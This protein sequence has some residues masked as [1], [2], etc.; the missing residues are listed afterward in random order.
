MSERARIQFC[1]SV[2]AI[3]ANPARDR[4]FVVSHGSSI[5]P[6][7]FGRFAELGVTYDT[8]GTWMSRDPSVEALTMNRLGEDRANR[9]YP[10]KSVADAQ[11]NVSLGSDWPVSGYVSEYRP[12][13]MI[14]VAVTRQ[15][16]GREGVPVGRP[17]SARRGGG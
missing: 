17:V 10:L 1:A 7:D 3:A 11:G 16:P 15:L 8:T 4:R 13:M 9:I 12:L 6:D 2:P 14:Q 5:H